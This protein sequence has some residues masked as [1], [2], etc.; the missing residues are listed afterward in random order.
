MQQEALF[1]LLS[2]HFSIH[3]ALTL[4]ALLTTLTIL[5][6]FTLSLQ[7]IMVTIKYL[8][9]S[10]YHNFKLQGFSGSFNISLMNTDIHVY[11][12]VPHQQILWQTG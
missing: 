9:S 2:S 8:G 6:N 7:L 12:N 5:A 3:D 11:M 4:H 1:S 10:E